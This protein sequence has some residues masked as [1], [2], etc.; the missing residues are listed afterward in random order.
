MGTM[1]DNVG[2]YMRPAAFLVVSEKNG[3]GK[4]HTEWAQKNNTEWAQCIDNVGAYMRPVVA[5]PRDC[6]PPDP[7]Q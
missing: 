4:N 3:T 2:A 7:C 1:L 5:L 6:A